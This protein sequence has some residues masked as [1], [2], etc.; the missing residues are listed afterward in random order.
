MAAGR[1]RSVNS[2]GAWLVCTAALVAACA[3]VGSNTTRPE[4]PWYRSVVEPT[5]SD[6]DRI[7]SFYDRLLTMERDKLAGELQMVRKSFEKERSDFNRLQ[8]AILLSLPDTSFRDDNAALA[9]LAPF[10]NE[11]QGDDSKLRPLA[12]W[13]RSELLE[14]RR[15]DEALQTQTA[16]AKEEQLR[17]DEALQQQTAKAKDEQRRADT[18]Q[19]KLEAI[20]DME[21]KMMERE[22]LPPKK[23]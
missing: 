11:A 19:Q 10:V 6:S 18:L 16:K 14:L 8:L 12:L 17:A 20:L 1:D 21:M 22:Q 23:K 2:K 9:L 15:A 13:L 3:P 4:T 7:I 5:E